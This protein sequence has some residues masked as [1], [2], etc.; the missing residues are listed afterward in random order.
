MGVV[1]KATDQVLERDVALKLM[2]ADVRQIPEA[3]ALFMQEAKALASLNHPNIVTVFDQGV[4]AGETF[5]VMELVEGTTLEA[6]LVEQRRFDLERVVAIA[7]QMCAGLAYAHERRVIH[8]DIKPANVFVTSA[9]AVKLGDFGLARVLNELRIRQTEVRGTPLYMAP[10]QIRG[11]DIDFRID[12]YAIG[13]TIYE[14]LTGRPPFIEG[15]VLFHHL[16]TEPEP[17]STHVDGIPPALDALI[18][19]CLAKEKEQRIR[20]A[21]AIRSMLAKV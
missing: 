9:G 5:M 10:E 21:D 12:L 1:Y 11:T 3:L 18:M 2:S 6:M 13:C 15:E 20:S 14:M 8:R 4:D 7:D 16:H 17:P 19:S